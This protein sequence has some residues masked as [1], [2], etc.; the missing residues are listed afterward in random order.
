MTHE[1][2][3]PEDAARRMA[4]KLL[5]IEAMV[6]A[7]LERVRRT[8]DLPCQWWQRRLRHWVDGVGTARAVSERRLW[9]I[10]SAFYEEPTNDR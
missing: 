3:R 7:E 6:D 8:D 10:K 5:R 4:G 9:K 2:E 1:T